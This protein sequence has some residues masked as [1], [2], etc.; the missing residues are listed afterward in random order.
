M[1]AAQA[2]LILLLL[3]STVDA[4]APP[5]FDCNFDNDFCGWKLYAKGFPLELGNQTTTA[6]T[7]PSGD[8]TSGSANVFPTFHPVVEELGVRCGRGEA[9][10][11]YVYLD[12]S[13]GTAGDIGKIFSPKIDTSTDTRCLTF[14]YH[15]H[16]PHA[17]SL[18]V[19]FTPIKGSVWGR[20]GDQGDDWVW[21]NLTL[22]SVT[23]KDRVRFK[24]TR[25]SDGIVAIDDVALADG[26]CEEVVM[27]LDAEYLLYPPFAYVTVTFNVSAGSPEPQNLMCVMDLRDGKGEVEFDLK[28]NHPYRLMFTDTGNYTINAAVS[29]ARASQ[30]ISRHV[31]V[32][33]KM[34]GPLLESS[35][36]AVAQNQTLDVRFYLYTG[37]SGHLC[38]LIWDFGNGTS[39]TRQRKGQG[40]NAF[41]TE[42]VTYSA[43][44]WYIIHVT[45]ETPLETVTA[46]Y[47]IS[48]IRTFQDRDIQISA[49][50]QHGGLNMVTNISVEWR[51]HGSTPDDV[52]VLIEFGEVPV[53]LPHGI[54]SNTSLDLQLWP[55]RKL[56]FGRSPSN[57]FV[58]QLQFKQAGQ[59]E[60]KIDVYAKFQNPRII[61][62]FR[63]EVPRYI[64]CKEGLEDNGLFFF[65]G[66]NISF[67]VMDDNNAAADRCVFLAVHS[68]GGTRTEVNLTKTTNPFVVDSLET[69]RKAGQWNITVTAVNP[70][71]QATINTRVIMVE[72]MLNFEITHNKKKMAPG[73]AKTF[74]ISFGEQGLK[75]CLT[76]DFGDSSP[77][78]VY[79]DDS[80]SHCDPQ[81]AFTGKLTGLRK[82]KHTYR[83][84]GYYKVTAIARSS[85]NNITRHLHLNINSHGCYPP[86]VNIENAAHVFYEPRIRK[87]GDI[88]KFRAIPSIE[89]DIWNNIKTWDI[90][91]IDEDWGNVTSQVDLT[92]RKV[93]EAELRLEPWTL[94]LKLYRVTFT[95]TLI[96]YDNKF[97]LTGSDYSYFKVVESALVGVMINGGTAEIVHGVGQSLYLTPLSFSFDASVLN[98]NPAASGLSVVSWTCTF[99]PT[100]PPGN[101]NQDSTQTCPEHLTT[102]PVAINGSSGRFNEAQSSL[103]QG[104]TYNLTAVLQ[105]DSRNTTAS[106]DIVVL[107]AG[108]SMCLNFLKEKL[109]VKSARLGLRA[110]C[111][112][113][114]GPDLETLR[115][116][117]NISLH[118]YRWVETGGWRPLQPAEMVTDGRTLGYETLSPELAIYP[119]LFEAFASTTHYRVE[120]ATT[121]T[122]ASGQVHDGWAVT[123]FQLNTPPRGGSCTIEPEEMVATVEKLFRIQC[124]GWQDDGEIEQYQFYT[125]HDN[126][127]VP[128]QLTWVM[129]SQGDVD[130]NVTIG[131]GPK[132]LNYY[133]N[134]Q[135][136][137]RDTMGAST[138][139]EIGAVRVTPSWI[140]SEKWK[141]DLK[142]KSA[143]GDLISV[144]EFATV[145][146]N[147]V[148]QN[149]L[150]KDSNYVGPE[151][152]TANSS[153]TDQNG[154]TAETFE[155][156]SEFPPA[157]ELEYEHERDERAVLRE[158]AVEAFTTMPLNDV[159]SMNQILSTTMELLNFPDEVTNSAQMTVMSIVRK[160][161]E[162]LNDEEQ[163][164]SDERIKNLKYMIA[165][166]GSCLAAGGLS[167]FDGTLTM[168]ERAEHT[169]LF[170][171]YD[172][173]SL[174][175]DDECLE[176]KK[177]KPRMIEEATQRQLR[178][179][180]CMLTR[181]N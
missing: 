21:A 36:P 80:S 26:K 45:A 131:R 39:V 157:A 59:F 111:M 81:A 52:Y 129:T 58:Q 47:N 162:N 16:G 124:Q 6:G 73:I 169:S 130:I 106:L 50:P 146:A 7:G 179:A 95:M 66:T 79:A 90:H 67:R 176:L 54:T 44:G 158:Q 22:N 84:E 110:N 23:D 101:P 149:K 113:N 173:D 19:E 142:K 160:M 61:K 139:Q 25:G 134:V 17:G 1:A 114:C 9:G 117:W 133:S 64:E 120:C 121:A 159:M 126:T 60:I 74:E 127:T 107:C 93:D 145:V 97:R 10:G 181:A 86:K 153:F 14:W 178:L 83:Q 128:L 99:R 2:V 75:T 34:S 55:P 89:S 164:T 147:N 155:Q 102:P 69:L 103:T 135:V 82:V 119:S 30:N 48:V 156:T 65:I 8:H 104:Y 136:V 143:E 141:K 125:Y 5:G 108:G 51:G 116:R 118:D 140:R 11:S 91:E 63:P 151:D 76:I 168:L 42:S 15:M 175:H 172:V 170:D 49:R 150:D 154:T 132:R 46:V 166:P 180:N 94:D 109:V 20:T 100:E 35:F 33:E 167:G 43:F 88:I 37:P 115:Y 85:H 96:G 72:K 32:L 70:M 171:D 24:L 98:N 92:G 57:P 77:V 122:D 62:C 112:E 144:T 41:D 4:A 28:L 31:V 165:A 68:E 13:N 174:A 12:A 78:E 138:M 137:V 152:T 123:Y 27:T 148:N 87:K 71:H 40:K 53:P 29:S 38:N 3:W 177:Q 161:T 105:K 163:V 56:P 18:E